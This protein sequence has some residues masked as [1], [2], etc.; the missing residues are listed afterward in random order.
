MDVLFAPSMWPESYGLV[1]REAAACGCWV[2]ASDLG[3]IGEDVIEGKTG[4][5]IEKNVFGLSKAV[6]EIDRCANKFKQRIA[7]SDI[8]VVDKQIAEL[9]SIYN[10]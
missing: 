2:V 1:T 4:L 9:V 3:G 5:R 10:D 8:R 6:K 7:Q